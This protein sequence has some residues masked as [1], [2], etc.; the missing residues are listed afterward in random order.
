V[1]AAPQPRG[2]NPWRGGSP[3]EHRL[4]RG[5]I[6]RAE[7]RI[8]EGNKALKSGFPSSLAVSP[9]EQSAL[10]SSDQRVVPAHVLRSFGIAAGDRSTYLRVRRAGVRVPRGVGGSPHAP[11]VE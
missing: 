9:W 1:K 10:C 6:G 8:L 3:G 4:L 2:R 11:L 5:L 7:V